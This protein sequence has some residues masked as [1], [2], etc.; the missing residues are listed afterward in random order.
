MVANS[1]GPAGQSGLEAHGIINPGIIHWNLSA[2]AL[3]QE[4]IRRGEGVVTFGGA[5]AVNTGMHTGRS[6]KD[7]FIVD[8][9][10]VRDTVNWG[11][12]N[13]P[14]EL[15]TF[16]RMHERVTAY[17][18]GRD[19]FVQDCFAGA[20][21]KHRLK[22]RVL[23]ESA[24]P[25][26]FAQNMFIRPTAE[27]K[28]GFQPDFTIL[29]TPGLQ[30][31]GEADGL[32][33]ETFIIV[34]F[35]ERMIL[36]GGS[37]YAGEIKKSIFGILNYLLPDQGVMPMHCSANIGTSGDSAI[38]FGLS[39]TGK[40]TLSADGSR[41]LIGDDEHGWSSN[42]IFN[43][44]GGCYAKVINLSAKAEPEIYSTIHR[45]GTVLENVVFDPLTRELDLFDGSL[46]E[47]TRACY[48]LEF[49]PNVSDNGMADHPNNI[50]ML[51]ADAF[52]VL[53]PIAKLSPE[54]AM[55]HFLSGY[56]ARVAGTEKGMGTQPEA[57]F[58]TCFGAPFMPRHPTVYGEMLRD[59]IA[60]H[61][62]TCWLVNT[63]WSGGRAGDG[64]ERMKI[65]YTR[66]MVRAALDGRLTAAPMQKDERFGLYVPE[67]CPDVPTEILRPGIAWLDKSS[68]DA[69]AAELCGRFSD[70]FQQFESHVDEAVVAAG[71]PPAA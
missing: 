2:P 34:N 32:N 26:L 52:G 39:G 12:V 15:E 64:G 47:N 57:T 5:F 20:D 56:T 11:S 54:Q 53:P 13:K 48:P 25:N 42:G 70:N 21:P 27:H 36:I 16:K 65:S 10:S 8:T 41:T 68:Y 33:S 37:H 58:S 6:P 7:K 51:T 38:F 45:F 63:G 43:F 28:I 71:I 40:T 22:V 55:Y 50:V 3:Y 49:I 9:P 67:S 62:S 1:V 31:R 69:T 44:E 35:D 66:A 24:W 23:T 60:R 46:T 14:V 18:Q 59:R 61:G 4:A 17:F 19:V 30:A 29:H